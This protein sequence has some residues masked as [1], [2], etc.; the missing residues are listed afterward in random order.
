MVDTRFRGYDM[1]KIVIARSHRRRSN[2]R[3]V[4]DVLYAIPTHLYNCYTPHLS[5]L[6]SLLVIRRHLFC[7]P[8]PYK[9]E[10]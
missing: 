2:P 8:S 10:G 1:V 3:G 5:F 4:S 9:G 7:V 6:P